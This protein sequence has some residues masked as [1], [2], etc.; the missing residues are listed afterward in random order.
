[1][2]MGIC[3]RI[4]KTLRANARNMLTVWRMMS[5]TM[6]FRSKEVEG[7]RCSIISIQSVLRL[8]TIIVRREKTTILSKTMILMT[9]PWHDAVAEAEGASLVVMVPEVERVS[10]EDHAKHWILDQSS[11]CFIQRPPPLSSTVIT[12][13]LTN[14]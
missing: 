4:V 6:S 3:P 7:M 8:T 11:R 14:L 9:P 1:M 5:P 13:A 12:T 10:N 2:K